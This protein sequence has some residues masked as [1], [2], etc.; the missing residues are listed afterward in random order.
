MSR[1][2][3]TLL[4]ASAL[5]L[6]ASP[7]T[8][9]DGIMPVSEIKP[10]MEGYGKTVFQGVKIE[11]FPFKVV[12]ILRNWNP[13]MDVI[14]I[15]C[16]GAV[17]EKAKIIQGMSGSPCYI[18][19]RLIGALAYGWSYNIDALAGVTP[20]EDMLKIADRTLEKQACLPIRRGAGRAGGLE[21]CKAPLF[22]TARSRQG[23][24]F[25][26]KM[27]EGTDLVPMSAGGGGGYGDLDAPLE[28]GAAISVILMSGDMEMFA[29]GTVT[30]TGGGR[31]LAF[32]HPFFGEG[33]HSMPVTNSWTYT[34]VAR[35]V[36][37]FKLSAPG[38]ILGAMTQDRSAGI[39]AE[40]GRKSAMIPLKIR[41]ENPK[42]GSVQSYS[43]SIVDHKTWTSELSTYALIDAL[44]NSEPGPEG[45]AKEIE[46]VFKPRGRD[47]VRV[48]S[49][50]SSGGGWFANYGLL[51][52]LEAYL[53]NPFEEVHVDS[54][55][56]D[57]RVVHED[58]RGAI[59]GVTVD[60][61]EYYPGETVSMLIDVKKPKKG[62]AIFPL[63]VFLPLNLEPG[64]HSLEIMAQDDVEPYD[65]P[66]IEDVDT[67]LRQIRRLSGRDSKKI[68]AVIRSP[69]FKLQHKGKS[70]ENVPFS[71]LSQLLPTL[72][73]GKYF[74]KT[75]IIES[76]GFST[77]LYV[78]GQKTLKITVKKKAE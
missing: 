53:G 46:L 20:I 5:L 34:V 39:C 32:G 50:V 17:V 66:V 51:R 70:M 65:V 56:I 54:I 24:E 9:E 11:T 48:K 31:I 4:I 36:T 12:D 62:T 55:S 60:R 37:S 15:K 33:E 38:K 25:L 2:L 61:D 3:P 64:E 18:Q 59:A 63:K 35:D 68:V 21:P 1:L 73:T 52:P 14:L 75:K 29:T 47:E 57:V 41:V 40:S 22:V 10:G 26:E 7:A 58:M 69:E 16:G 72:K 13:G 42:T 76:E 71:V 74:I 77:G 19:G 23:M 49:F 67:L 8:A 78:S 6:W 28:P 45:D 27:L 43:M 30:W 44:S